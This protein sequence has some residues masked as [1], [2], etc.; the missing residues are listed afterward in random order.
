ML[1]KGRGV[2]SSS[3]PEPPERLRADDPRFLG[4]YRLLGRLGTGGM[5]VVYLACDPAAALP[6]P[7]PTGMPTLLA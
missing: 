3:L 6:R 2:I 5:G 7:G 4:R 1:E